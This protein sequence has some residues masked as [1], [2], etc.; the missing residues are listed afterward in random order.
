MKVS[1]QPAEVLMGQVTVNY[2]LAGTQQKLA[3]S[4]V[5]QG[6]YATTYVIHPQLIPG[7]QW[8]EQSPTNGWGQYGPTDVQVSFYYV[9]ALIL[10]RRSTLTI[11]AP[12]TDDEQ[13]AP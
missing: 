1:Q 5:H 6:N 2:Y 8:N 10:P 12:T 3:P 7:Y 13:S 4:V 11:P 9:P